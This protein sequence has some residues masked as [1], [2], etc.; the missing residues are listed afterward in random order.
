M[1]EF[2]TLQ[3][4]QAAYE[5]GSFSAAARMLDVSQPSVSIAIAKLE[6]RIGQK[7]FERKR[8]GLVP[9]ALGHQ[10][11]DQSRPLLEQMQRV[12]KVMSGAVVEIARIHCFPD[13]LIE[14]ITS[15]LHQ[16]RRSNLALT[17]QFSDD[18]DRSDLVFCS[19]DCV[20]QGFG[21]MALWTE[22]YGLGVHSGHALARLDAVNLE[23]LS[24]APLISRA[25]CPA[26]DRFFQKAAG[27]VDVVAEAL[28]DAQLI[29]LLKAGLGVALLPQTHV[30]GQID[31]AFVPLK[32]VE[33][34]QRTVCVAFRK[35]AFA[36]GLASQ[37]DRS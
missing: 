14:T 36:Q 4:F 15:R 10:I 9:T 19:Q 8:N 13:V 5:V 33:D 21:F 37:F 29:G 28:H 30:K 11:Y 3:Y 32:G 7:V 25:Y 12:E 27:K 20:P 2:Q 17:I 1:V 26:A 24:G 31:L 35:T 34:T 16:L 23:D 22:R 18:P 6:A